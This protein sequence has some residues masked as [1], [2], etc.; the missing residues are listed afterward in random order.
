MDLSTVAE[1]LSGE[2]MNQPALDIRKA[3]R[4]NSVLGEPIVLFLMSLLGLSLFVILLL[5][6]DRA[7]G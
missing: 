7:G 5:V 4:S 6:L 1:A 2:T 3:P